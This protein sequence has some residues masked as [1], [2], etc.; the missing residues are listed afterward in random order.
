MHKIGVISDTHGLLRE[1]VKEVLCTCDAIFHG[2]D[3]NSYQT[4]E[5]LEA[6]APLYAVRGNTD[7]KEWASRLPLTCSVTLYGIKIFMIHNKNQIRE[8]VSGYDVVLYGHSHK[9]EQLQKDGQI[10]LNPGS[11]GARRF[12]LPVTM[13]VMTVTRHAPLASAEDSIEHSAEDSTENFSGPFAE[14]SMKAS[15][16]TSIAISRIDLSAAKKPAPAE[17]ILTQQDLKA[18]VYRVM[19]ET[20]KGRPV[21]TI[22]KHCHI[23]VALATQICRLYLTHPGV[24]ADGI[25]TKMGL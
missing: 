18:T 3:I 21:E 20:D 23:S 11:C 19:R 8:D 14:E 10:W 9:Y 5:Q 17:E 2:G 1:N 22:A 25:L 7:T 12:S 4:I 24:T 16:K 15:I 13:A 6:I